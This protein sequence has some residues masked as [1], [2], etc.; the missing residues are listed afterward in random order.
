MSRKIRQGDVAPK[1]DGASIAEFEAGEA[2]HGSQELA[3]AE[4]MSRHIRIL[5]EGVPEVF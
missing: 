5:E 1:L 4:G 3:V 2:L